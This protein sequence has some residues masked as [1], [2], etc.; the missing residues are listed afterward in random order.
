MLPPDV[1]AHDVVS[2]RAKIEVTE[3]TG[4]VRDVNC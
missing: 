2:N 1:D 3:R 4:S